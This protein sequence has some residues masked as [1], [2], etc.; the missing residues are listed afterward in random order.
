MTGSNR[1]EDNDERKEVEQGTSESTLE[2]MCQSNSTKVI[3][4]TR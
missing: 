2:T 1:E 3:P 4:C